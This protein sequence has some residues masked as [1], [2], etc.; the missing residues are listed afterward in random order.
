MPTKYT[1]D[2]AYL[3]DVCEIMR[4]HRCGEHIFTL[5]AHSLHFDIDPELLSVTFITA[6]EQARVWLVQRRAGRGVMQYM[7]CP[8][9]GALRR[10]LVATGRV[11]GC[12]AC[13]GLRYYGQVASR[14]Q[15]ARE[16]AWKLRKRLDPWTMGFGEP[17]PERPVGMRRKQ[18]VGLVRR[19]AMAA[20]RC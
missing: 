11:F 5:G 8:A 10:K 2:D 16:M 6:T 1:I 18:Y 12:R 7:N 4:L 20:S 9:C 19:I 14:R 17:I 15:R 3:I 13:F